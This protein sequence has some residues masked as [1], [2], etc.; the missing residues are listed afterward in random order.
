M[1]Q[2][3][4]RQTINSVNESVQKELARWRSFPEGNPNP[5]LEVSQSGQ[6]EYTNASAEKLFP[7][8]KETTTSHPY[9]VDWQ[10]AVEKICRQP[11][12]NLARDVQV[13]DRCY[14]QSIF[15][16]KD[17]GHLRIYG[18]DVTESKRMEADLRQSQALLQAVTEGS[19]DPIFIKDRQSQL[20]MA[21]PATLALIGK[22][23]GQVIG[24]TDAEFYDIREVGLAIMENDRRIMESG[25]TEVV[26]EQV[27]TADHK[28][29]YLSTK[30]PWRN[31]EGEVIGLLGVARDIT[32]RKEKEKQLRQ[33][34]RTL[35][36]LSNS[37]QA[38]MHVEDESTFMKEVCRIVVEDCGYRM[39][40]IGLAE[41]D[42]GKTVRPV[43]SAGFEEGYLETLK[44]TWA[45]SERGRGPTGTAVRTG[46]PVKCHNMLTDPKFKPWREQA[47][48]RGYASSIALPLV[49][50]GKTI[51]ALTIYSPEPDSFHEDEVKLLSELAGDLAHGIISAKL[52]AAHARTEEALK[53]S[54]EKY[55][56]LIENVND[57]VCEVDSQG[58][59]V[60]LSAQYKQILGYESEELIGAYARDLIHPDDMKLS[61]PTFKKLVDDRSVSHNEWRFKH[62]NGEWRW[63][64]CVGQTYEKSPGVTHVVV[65]SRDIT[66]RRQMEKE[67]QEN[68]ERYR[69]L[70]TSMT[71]GFALHEIICDDNDR[72]C[73]Y[74]FLEINPAFETLTGLKRE[75]VIGKTHN[76]ILPGDD[77]KWSQIYGKV[78]LTGKPVHFENY[79]PALEQHYEVYAYRPAPRQFAVIFTNITERKRLEQESE[80]LLARVRQE[81]DRL[82][83][84]IDNIADEV[85]F[86]DEKGNVLL[87]N[88]IAVQNLGY[89]NLQELLVPI[90]TVA[91]DLE[92]Y[93]P[94][95]TLRPNDEAVLTQTL[96]GEPLRGEEIVRNKRTGEMKYRE[97][98]AVPIRSEGGRISGAVAIVRDIT[99]RK[100]TEEKLV[101]Q[102][103]MLDRAHILVRDMDSR[104]IFWNQGA[105]A[106]YGYSS[107]EALGKT[108]HELLQ[109]VFPVS[110]E[111]VDRAL[112]ATGNWQGELIHTRRDG[113][114]VYIA[115]HQV[116]HYDREHHPLAIIETNNDITELKI[117]EQKL[118]AS[119]ERFRLLMDEAPIAICVS[120]DSKALYANSAYLEMHGIA[121]PDEIIGHPVI[122][123]VAPES[124]S[125]S[126]E[127]TERRA[128]G[129]A[130]DKRY[131]YTAVRKDGSQIPTLA[132]VTRV[133]LA[134][135][136]ATIGFFQDISERKQME[137][138]L[139]KAHDELELRVQER[140]EQLQSLNEELRA[141]IAEREQAEEVIRQNVRRAE[142][143]SIIAR[144][145]AA[146]HL[147]VQR[148]CDVI[149]SAIAES[150]G[151]SCGVCLF[152]EVEQ[153]LRLVSI[154]YPD[155]EE[156]RRLA[157]SLNSPPLR[158]GEGMA[159]KVFQSGKALFQPVVSPRQAGQLTSPEH[160]ADFAKMPITSLMCVPVRQDQKIV[161]T[162]TLLRFKGLSYTQEDLRLLEDVA[163]RAGLSIGKAILYHELELALQ[164]EQQARLQL[165]QNEKNSA[166]AR[167]VASVAHEINNPI[168]TIKNCIYLLKLKNEANPDADLREALTMAGSEANRIGDLVGRL[169]DLYRPTREMNLKPFNIINVLH[170]VN[171]L[172]APH[173]QQNRIDFAINS[174]IDC[175]YVNGISDQIKQVFLN[176]CLNSIDAMEQ[177]GG[178]LSISVTCP[179]SS[180]VCITFK[181]SGKGIHP[182]IIQNIFEPFYTTKETG[183]GLGL[184][185]CSEIIKN[186]NGTIAA[187]SKLGEGATFIVCLPT[188]L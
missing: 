48:R 13:H 3:K 63:F 85:W 168:Q 61:T 179:D 14:H 174:C 162:I 35:R 178:I 149:S 40:W 143:L 161:G 27:I 130:V 156:E 90:S 17:S 177:Q 124:V 91:D 53:E 37:N 57:L 79:S 128:K 83:A 129:L 86:C 173:L 118:Q 119:E 74:R 175:V 81:R 30:T 112:S 125:A 19:P 82:Q 5:I 172:L 78:A 11:G 163:D 187:E 134:D 65:I 28:R 23:A 70:F 169:R 42:E 77:P 137:E 15:F 59:Y 50:G 87:A 45:D 167:M 114:K 9:L 180:N 171:A 110:R 96:K 105:E 148:V 160:K 26:E 6:I 10:T 164:R 20:L 7:D 103:R 62:K 121:N 43:A 75:N 46:K 126:E 29:T 117:A 135:G 101:E 131:E 97:Y 8:L 64:D 133:N 93:R 80:E 107:D 127:R 2:K 100:R 89:N 39:V 181:D 109:T 186:H 22:P 69:S 152:S 95:G 31:A 106:L 122:E 33:L 176:L 157:L 184:A 25:Q 166:L 51:G 115:S 136:P 52:R 21:N 138:N 71:E 188:I 111:D 158:V 139:R 34:N 142:T 68:E 165:I 58:K 47:L 76:E 1:S 141:E 102:A 49:S 84:L 104:I 72:P 24:K 88:K 154:R 140:T 16:D 94:D 41:N 113:S 108:T 155:S 183:T 18:F 54:E 150:L 170:E 151:D 66:K 56:R 185:I 147:D 182:E 55:R 153:V 36:A 67:L 44:I 159:G 98:N 99:E 32:D 38:M 146:A 60:F 123:N 12:R 116:V 132:A 120:R 92:I 4:Q 73:D 145:L 144:H